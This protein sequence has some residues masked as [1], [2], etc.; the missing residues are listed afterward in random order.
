MMGLDDGLEAHRTLQVRFGKGCFPECDK[1][2]FATG[3]RSL[4]Y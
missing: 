3:K 1:V 4:N 2:R